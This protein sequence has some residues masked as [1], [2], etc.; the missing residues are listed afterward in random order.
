MVSTTAPGL[1]VLG[2]QFDPDWSATVDGA[3]AKIHRVDYLMRGL[4]IGPG[5]HRVRFTYAPHALE[6]GIRV[7]VLSLLLTLALAGAG[8]LQWRRRKR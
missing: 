6:A 3:P 4:L 5:V 7:S 1:F 2:D 8:A